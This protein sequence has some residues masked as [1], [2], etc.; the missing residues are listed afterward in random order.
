MN[1]ALK[2]FGGDQLRDVFRKG[3]GLQAEG[4]ADVVGQHAEALL[5]HVHDGDQHVAHGAGALRAGAQR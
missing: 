4:T 1:R 3:A 2:F 5:R